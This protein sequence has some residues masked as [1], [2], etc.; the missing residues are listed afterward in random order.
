[1]TRCRIYDLRFTIYDLHLMHHASRTTV[2]ARRWSLVVGRWSVHA[3]RITFYVLRF[4]DNSG[5][6]PDDDQHRAPDWDGAGQQ[7]EGA[8]G[9]HAQRVPYQAPRLDHDLL[10]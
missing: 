7:P 4:T 8:L 10:P 9:R 5:L 6:L 2:L 3:S 1:M